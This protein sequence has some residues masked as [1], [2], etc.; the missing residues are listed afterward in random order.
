MWEPK[1]IKL[2]EDILEELKKANT[3][4]AVIAGELKPPRPPAVS[5]KLI[6]G[7]PVSQ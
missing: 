5:Q 6:L 4:L 2:L 3:T 1:K 7:K